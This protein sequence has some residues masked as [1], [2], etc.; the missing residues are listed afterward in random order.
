MT[1]LAITDL[2]IANQLDSAAMNDVTGGWS[3]YNR[4]SWCFRGKSRKFVGICWKNG[5]RVR[6]YLV[7]KTYKQVNFRHDFCY[8]YKRIGC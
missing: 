3:R 5:H 2:T 1:A 8:D 7:K 6:K 4:G